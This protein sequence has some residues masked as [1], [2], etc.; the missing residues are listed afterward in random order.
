[1]KAI[2]LA[3]RLARDLDEKSVIDLA[4]DTKLEILDAINGA[5]QKIHALSPHHTKITTAS[6]YLDA[7]LAVSI[8]VT[9]GDVEVTGTTFTADQYGRT[10]RIDGD[11]IDNQVAGTT[12]LL[13]PY[14][15]ATGT[16]SAT[17]YGDAVALPEPYSELVGDPR[18]LETG[19]DLHHKKI[20]FVTWQRRNVC[21]PRFYWVEPNAANRASSAPAIVRF[22]T[23]PDSTYRLTCEAMLAPAR[24]SFSDLLAPGPE[25]SIRQEH[26]EL[27]LLPIARG[28]LTSCELWKNRESKPA[29]LRAAE[30][31]EAKYEVLA[32]TTL[33]TPSNEVGT[34]Y[35]F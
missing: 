1:M 10:I 12:S 3:N 28:L 18:V 33:A 5:L 30:T 8:G 32:S 25:L 4:A 24:V 7:P 27:Y 15:G 21:E 16:V 2:A 17:V 22:D 9:Q 31:A 29:A 6:L 23:L 11:T 35:G 20:R 19:R 26:V 14:T 13:H 34:P